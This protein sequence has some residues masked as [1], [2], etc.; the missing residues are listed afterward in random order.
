MPILCLGVSHRRA[1]VDLLERLAFSEDGLLKAYRRAEDDPALQETVILST[2]NRVEAYANVPAYHP[3][4]LALKR[5]LE[6]SADVD[7]KELA[8]PLYSHYERDAAEHLFSVSAGLDSVLLGETQI[9][10]QVRDAL[11]RAQEE[12]AAGRNLAALF[13][14][15]TRAGRRVRAETSLGAA[16]DALVALA[17]ALAREEIGALGD[18]TAVVVGAGKMAGLAA[19]HLRRR[20]VGEIQV[21]N[22][23]LEHARTLAQRLDARAG[24]LS[25][26]PIALRDA[27]LLVTATGAP[28]AVVSEE[29][30]RRAVRSRRPEHRLMLVDLA[31]PRDVEASVTNIHAVRLV[32]MEILRHR[33]DRVDQV[34]TDDVENAR[35]IVAEEVQRWMARRRADELAPLLRAV[36]SRGDEVIRAE[37]ER[38]A[39]RLSS[40][41]PDEFESVRALAEGI[42]AKLLHAPISTLKERSEGSRSP[43]AKLLAELLGIDPE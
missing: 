39:S 27:D 28:G 37:L 7:E 26:L 22:R 29:D 16:P 5:L 38:N 43:H 36:R 18:A 8:E 30:V 21:L 25:H 32:D 14:A 12:G 35:A 1:G 31:V 10:G 40:L 13:Q 15:A 19:K 4:F 17:V 6:A 9:A 41:S 42:V 34:T 24:D 23:S 20:G 2:C 33:L 3:G 11:R